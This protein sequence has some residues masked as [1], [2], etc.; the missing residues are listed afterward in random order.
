MCAMIF[1]DSQHGFRRNLS[2]V[3]AVLKPVNARILAD[4][5]KAFDCVPDC[6]L[7]DKLLAYGVNGVVN[8]NRVFK[9]YNLRIGNRGAQRSE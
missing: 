2:T 9:S 8:Q 6:Q 7:Q 1:S 4:L 3:T 5:S